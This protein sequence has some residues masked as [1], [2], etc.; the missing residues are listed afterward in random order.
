[1]DRGICMFPLHKVITTATQH[2]RISWVMPELLCSLTTLGCQSKQCDGKYS[3]PLHPSHNTAS[4]ESA[5]ARFA[6]SGRVMGSVRLGRRAALCRSS[7]FLCWPSPDSEKC[8]AGRS[9]SALEQ[10]M[11]STHPHINCTVR[12]LLR[13]LYVLC[14]WAPPNQMCPTTQ[15]DKGAKT[16]SASWLVSVTL[17]LAN[18]QI[19]NQDIFYICTRDILNCRFNCPLFS[20]TRTPQRFYVL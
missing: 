17:W 11:L 12:V 16:L 13:P 3:G 9:Y 15:E 14:L 6:R 8:W 4:H 10:R 1:M 7:V 5:G 18:I 2:N 19:V 20:C